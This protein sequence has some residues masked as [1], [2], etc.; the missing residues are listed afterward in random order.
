S[1]AGDRGVTEIGRRRVYGGMITRLL[2]GLLL[3]TPLGRAQGASPPPRPVVYEPVQDPAKIEKF[4]Y[5]RYHTTD[6]LGREIPVYLSHLRKPAGSGEAVATGAGKQEALP[7][8]VCVQGSGSQSVFV[9]VDTA[10]GKR[11]GSGGPESV[12]LKEFGDRVRVLVVE[13]PGV[14]FLVQ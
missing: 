14:E 12:V 7:L 6:A 9:E 3:L 1:S 8:V 10:Q 2:I 11:I 4:P 5:Q 13:K